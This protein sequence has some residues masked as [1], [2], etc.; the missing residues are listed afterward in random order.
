[1]ELE[2]DHQANTTVMTTAVKNHKQTGWNTG[3]CTG[4]RR[5]RV[6]APSYLLASIFPQ[7][8]A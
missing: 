1:M 4:G 8:A 5:E 7:K 3:Q 2:N 6:K